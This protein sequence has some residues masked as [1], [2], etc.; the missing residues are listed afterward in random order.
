MADVKDPQGAV[1][2]KIWD[3]LTTDSDLQDLFGG[4]VDLYPIEAEKDPEVPYMVHELVGVDKDIIRGDGAYYLDI[5][6]KS[7]TVYDLWKINRRVKIL[8]TENR[9]QTP[10]VQFRTGKIDSFESLPT[11][12]KGMN[13]Y[14]GRWPLQYQ[15]TDLVQQILSR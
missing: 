4:S 5:Y 9:F 8:L 15:K 10:Y 13:H 12:T 3:Y 7:D 1:L 11:K 14:S 6:D 2:D